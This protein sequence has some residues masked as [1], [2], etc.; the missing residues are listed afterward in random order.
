MMKLK[1]YIFGVAL[2][3]L[4]LTCASCYN[5]EQEFPDYE[6]GTKAY[7]AYQNPVR[8]LVLGNDIYDNTLDNEHK[9]RIWATM[10]GAYAGRNATV[11][12]VVDESL[13]DNLWFLDDGGYASLRVTPMPEKYYKLLSNSIS[14]NGDARGYVEVQFSDDF[15]ND[16][17]A[18]KN[19][20][21][22]PLRM[23]GVTGIDAI[24]SGTPNVSNPIRTNAQDWAVLPMDYVLYCV[25]YMNP[26]QG[27]YI[28]RGVDMVTENGGEPNKVVRKDFTL[29]NSDVEHYS[30]MDPSNPVNQN[31]EVCGITTKNRTEAI[32][33]VSFK[34]SGASISCNLILKFNGDKCTITSDDENVTAE[35]EGEFI[36]K[37]TERSEYK[38]YQWGSSNGK[39]I[40]RDILR[41][42]YKV[43]FI[44]K[45]IQVETKDTMVVQTRESNKRE[46]F[47]YKYEIKN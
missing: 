3:A 44:D 33:P 34:T 28:R 35:G 20:Y 25:K 1:K 38:D 47:E 37:G 7:F 36:T 19:T 30:K 42:A 18:I 43:N 23:T 39:L 5:S 29:Y 4:A 32:F 21:V 12:V 45:N 17:D 8:T 40:Q 46:F 41:L 26:W 24:L 16:P 22:I 2:G 11:N 27:K 6:G 14:Y 13:C 15:F 31:D 9:C 10:G